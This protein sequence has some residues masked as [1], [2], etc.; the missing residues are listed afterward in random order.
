VNRVRMAIRRL[1]C[2]L[3]GHDPATIR[4]IQDVELRDYGYIV[5]TACW[6][7]RCLRCGQSSSTPDISAT[8]LEPMDGEQ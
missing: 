8:R 1:T 3:L 4:E 5:K 7:H 2:R 6:T